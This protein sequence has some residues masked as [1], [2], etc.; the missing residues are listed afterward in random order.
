MNLGVVITPDAG[1]D[2]AEAKNWYDSQ[3]A[4]AGQKFYAAFRVPRSARK[5]VEIASVATRVGR[6]K[7]RK[8]KIPKFPYAIYYEIA[9]EEFRVPAVVHGARNPKYLNYR[10]R[11]RP[12]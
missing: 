10:L 5:W 1:L 12:R 9:G 4:N 6:R 11:A 8:M 7:I 3:A 2:I